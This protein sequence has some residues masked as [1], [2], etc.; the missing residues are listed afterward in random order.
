MR[1]FCLMWQGTDSQAVDLH[2]KALEEQDQFLKQ[3]R[4]CAVIEGVEETVEQDT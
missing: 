4:E 3:L 1:D 2:V